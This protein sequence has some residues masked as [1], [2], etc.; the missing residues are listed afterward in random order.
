MG[1]LKFELQ[2]PERPEEY[3]AA[4]GNIPSIPDDQRR[5]GRTNIRIAAALQYRR[6]IPSLMRKSE[7]HKIVMRDISRSGVS[8]LHSEQVYPTEQLMLIMPD[9]KPRSIE[10]MRCRRLSNQC[11]EV[12]ANFIQKLR[13]S[14]AHN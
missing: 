4:T 14:S 9:G 13:S 5:Y 8:F 3:F 10:V 7:W 1:P 6:S 2:L 11:Y 12:G